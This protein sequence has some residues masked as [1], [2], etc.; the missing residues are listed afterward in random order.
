MNIPLEQLI[1]LGGL[2]HLAL[3][4]PIS[5]VPFVLDWKKE[6]SPLPLMLR[7]LFWTYGGFIAGIIVAFGLIS[8][9]LATHLVDGHPVSRAFCGLIAV[10]WTARL[11]VEFTAFEVGSYLNTPFKKYSYPFLLL[12]FAAMVVI[13]A[14]VGIKQGGI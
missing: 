4:I 8:I 14:Y 12:N 2:L 3:I 9:G 1:R 5:L 7:R 10:F 13:Y 11:I 6:L